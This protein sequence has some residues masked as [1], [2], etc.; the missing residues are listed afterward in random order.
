MPNRFH[1]LCVL[2]A[3]VVLAMIASPG[4]ET[5]T[6]RG[7]VDKAGAITAVTAVDRAGDKKYTGTINRKTG[8]FTIAGLPLGASYDCIIDAGAVRLEGVNLKVPRSDYEEEQPLTADD[9]AAIKKAALS[10][11]KFENEIEVL[12]V[13]GNIQH[14][15]VVLNKKRTTPF[16]ESKPG[17]MIW[18]L[19]LWHF[20]KPDETWIKVQEEFAVVLYRER[21]QKGDFARKAL[22]LDPA[23]GGLRPDARQKVVDLGKIVLPSREPGIRLRDDKKEK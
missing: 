23:L 18:R 12:A 19:E 20:E 5:G 14:A 16:Y 21:L 8:G 13:R 9:V 2:A 17:E 11:N 22:T 6:I 4:A 7:T 1:C 15:A 3:A 10:L